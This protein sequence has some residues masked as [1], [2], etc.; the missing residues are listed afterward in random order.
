MEL[1]KEK[2]K[3]IVAMLKHA[4][5]EDVQEILIDSGWNKQMLHQLM[6]CESI[7]DVNYIYQERLSLLQSIKNTTSMKN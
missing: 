6:M 1:S 4:D 5:G 7:N 3:E 2:I